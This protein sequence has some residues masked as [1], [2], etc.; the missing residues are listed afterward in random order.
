M[1][2]CTANCVIVGL[3][4]SFLAS[5]PQVIT[6]TNDEFIVHIVVTVYI[7]HAVV[8]KKSIKYK[9]LQANNGGPYYPKGLSFRTFPEIHTISTLCCFV[10]ALN[11]RFDMCQTSYS[12]SQE[13]CTRFCCALLCCGYAIVNNEFTWSIYSYSSGLLCWHW[14]NR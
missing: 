13:I 7:V 4:N 9:C 12:I 5:W 11:S 8:E 1:H 2:I 14:G 6:W 10:V 3:D